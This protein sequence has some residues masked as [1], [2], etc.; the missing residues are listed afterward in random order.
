MGTCG[1][2]M[3]V[4]GLGVAPLLKDTTSSK[5]NGACCRGNARETNW[6]CLQSHRVAG[7]SVEASRE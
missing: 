5:G 3:A 1:K 4:T 2:E 7:L 6:G